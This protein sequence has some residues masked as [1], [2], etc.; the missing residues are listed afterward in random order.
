L[1]IGAVRQTHI[2]TCRRRRSET[3]QMLSRLITCVVAPYLW[4]LPCACVDGGPAIPIPGI[5]GALVVDHHIAVRL[6][7]QDVPATNS[8][9]QEPAK[10]SVT[11]FCTE[12]DGESNTMN[13][14][15]VKR[16]YR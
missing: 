3:Q 4:Q 9:N 2:T 11:I 14:T 12:Q 8:T 5:V 7:G 6:A 13:I 1:S 10:A 16:Q 15:H